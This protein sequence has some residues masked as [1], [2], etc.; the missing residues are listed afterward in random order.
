MNSACAAARCSTVEAY[1]RTNTTK[2][3]DGKLLTVDNQIDVTTGTIKLRALFDNKD[4]SLFPNQFVNIQLLR[5]VLKDQIIMPVAAV[6]RGAPNG[7]EQ[8]IRRTW[9]AP[10]TR[11]RCGP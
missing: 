4:G 5:E 1:D 6:Q 11:F 9:S 2:L 10:T 3:A 7:V 8:H